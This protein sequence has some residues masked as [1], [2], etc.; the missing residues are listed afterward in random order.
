MAEFGKAGLLFA[1]L[2]V[3]PLAVWLGAVL[4]REGKPLG[5][6]VAHRFRWLVIG[7]MLVHLAVGTGG[8]LVAQGWADTLDAVALV[9]LAMLF[10]PMLRRLQASTQRRRSSEFSPK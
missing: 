1:A 6:F 4:T 10:M 3:L 5:D 2:V 8:P 7:L 9:L